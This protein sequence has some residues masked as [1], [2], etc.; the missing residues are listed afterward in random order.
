MKQFT[1][2]ILISLYVAACGGGSSSGS[3]TTSENHTVGAPGKLTY[4]PESCSET[5]QIKFVNDV[6]HDIYLWSREIKQPDYT[7]YNSQ[8]QLLADLRYGLDDWSYIVSKE[9][10][11]AHYA[12]D[13]VGL[14]LNLQYDLEHNNAVITY[15]YK[16][17]PADIAGLRRGYKITSVNGY[18]IQDMTDNNSFDAAFGPNQQGYSV[19]LEYLDNTGTAGIVNVTKDSYYANAVNA[20]NIFTNTTNGKKIGY[21][22]YLSFT[23]NYISDL[24][25]ALTAFKTENISE[26]IID[27]R[28][29]SGG[30][31]NGAKYIA[32]NISG[33]SWTGNIFI[34]F[35][36]NSK[37]SSWNQTA[38]FSS[39]LAHV[40]ID[41][42]I[43]LTTSATASASELLINGLKPY[44]DTHL[45]GSTTHGKP[46][47][48]YSFEYCGNVIA[49]ISFQLL[50]S[51]AE[52]GYFNGLEPDCTAVDDTE[53]QLGDAE[54]SMIAAAINYLETG[55]CAGSKSTSLQS[56]LIAEKREGIH[57]IFNIR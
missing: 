16:D 25:E 42:V 18:T 43:F 46:V 10:S 8:N 2:I 41:K 50:N 11:D 12:G 53:H 34:T 5:D 48:M 35:L 29:N 24:S 15:I 28:Y 54:E 3:A 47:G 40:D 19:N 20:Y 14:G 57:R 31:I 17:S 45:V 44:I 55:T 26:L 49:P 38:L 6:M 4:E 56:S 32:D 9:I 30:L 36:H 39:P 52:G 21:I 27:L 33:G 13:N 37:Y 22:S 23:A 1:L 7:K 51:R